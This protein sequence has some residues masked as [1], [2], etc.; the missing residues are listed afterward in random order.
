[1]SLANWLKSGKVSVSSPTVPGLPDPV[2]MSDCRESLL[3]QTANSAVETVIKSGAPC[4]SRKRKRG[5]YSCY[6]DETRAKIARFAVDNGVAKAARKFSNSLGKKVSETTVRSMRDSYVKIKKVSMTEPKDLPKSPRGN[7]LLLGNLDSDVQSWVK[8]VRLSGGV[9][10]SRILM[11]AA[12]AIV[13]KY[14]KH[15]LERYGGHIVIT[16]T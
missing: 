16:K 1:M 14:A 10:N 5:E 9:V 3:T 11:A 13:T 4:A 6:D 15:K 2:T 8:N 7:P 12:E